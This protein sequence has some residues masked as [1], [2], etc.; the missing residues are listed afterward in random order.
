VRN[1]LYLILN[2]SVFIVPFAFSFYPKANFSKKWK[3]VIPGILITGVFFIVWD[4][5]FTRMGIWGFNPHYLSGIYI[6][7]LPLEEILFFF[8]I[9]YASIFTYFAL[10]YLVETDYFLP[11]HELISNVVIL[12]LLIVGIYNIDKSYTG[13]T[14]VLTGLFLSYQLLKLRTRYMGRFYFAFVFILIPFFI[15]NGILTGSFIQEPVVHY[16]DNENLGLRVGTI[17][18]EDVVYGMLMVLMSITIAEELEVRARR[19]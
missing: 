19:K 11:Y 8:C 14:F 7:S 3:F 2:I 10:T 12:L 13:V 6:S 5:L 1:Y 4:E 15:I 16:N 18:I 17:P 9:P